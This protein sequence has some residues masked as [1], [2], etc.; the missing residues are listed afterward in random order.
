MKDAALMVSL[1]GD[2]SPTVSVE[3]LIG[4]ECWFFNCNFFLF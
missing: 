1:A 3:G 4:M 2:T